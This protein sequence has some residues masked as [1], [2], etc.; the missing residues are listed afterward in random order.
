[1]EYKGT[2]IMDKT[3]QDKWLDESLSVLLEAFAKD[4]VI[5][6]ILVFKG[7]RILK[8]YIGAG[9]RF[10]KDIDS[11]LSFEFVSIHKIKAERIS[12]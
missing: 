12:F 10:S 4:Q 11:S 3:T 1:M 6:D 7:A 9:G 5:R 8:Y 2:L